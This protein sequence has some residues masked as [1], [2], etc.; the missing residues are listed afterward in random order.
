MKKLLL[1]AAT[2]CT[3]LA[4]NTNEK[5]V[6]STAP[7]P[8]YS[9]YQQVFCLNMLSNISGMYNFI[10]KDSLQD[11][12]TYAVNTVLADTNTIKLIGHWKPVWGPVV[13]SNDKDSKLKPVAVNTMFIAKNT[14]SPGLYVIAIAGTNPSS[15]TAWIDEDASVD[16]VISWQNALMLNHTFISG[17]EIQTDTAFVSKGTYTGLAKLLSMKD[18]NRNNITAVQY[19]QSIGNSNN[20]GTPVTLWVTGHSLGG[21]LSP[22]MALY[23]NDTKSRWASHDTA[24]SIHCLAVAGATPGDS[25]FSVY[26][27]S[28]LGANTI[29]VWNAHDVVPHGY[30]TAM[31]NKIRNIYSLDTIQIKDT[32][33]KDSV[34]VLNTP[35]EVI[36]AIDLLQK[37]LLNQQKVKTHLFRK[38]STYDLPYKYTQLFPSNG[39][40]C[41][42]TVFMEGFYTPANVIDPAD[43]KAPK[44]NTFIGQLGAQHI[45]SY[46]HY[47]G[48]DSFQYT[49]Q[50]RLGYQYPFFSFGYRPAPILSIQA[51]P[52][53]PVNA[54]Q[55]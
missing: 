55:K 51:D 22:A 11:T 14:D 34:V 52:A 41:Y 24:F 19:L 47:F 54:K 1:T 29:R 49:I 40:A 43:P 6:K 15:W 46:P 3:L 5:S 17:K 38:D 30:D 16:S 13:I 45:P 18:K 2:L 27:S 9:T 37:K 48:V 20:Q 35:I 12:T 7:V 8:Q 28:K 4:C 50:R 39:T 26:Y 44:P 31:I 42:D 36:I 25:A 33:K 23:L 10:D 21:A 53:C 32:K